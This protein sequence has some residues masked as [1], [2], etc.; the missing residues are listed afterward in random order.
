MD[1]ADEAF[2][3][4]LAARVPAAQ[5]AE[6]HTDDLYLACACA[7]GDARAI[8]IFHRRHLAHL[9]EALAKSGL[10]PEIADEG[11]QTLR[12]QLFVAA[13]GERPLIEGYSGR[14]AVAGWLRVAAMR[15]ASK[16]RRGEARR[17][18]VAMNAAAAAGLPAVD[19]ELSAIRRRYGDASNDAFRDAFGRLTSEERTLLRLRFVDGLNIERIGVV[20]G[21]SR[22]TVGRRMIA[23]RERLLEE[24][25]RALGERIQ[26]TPT[27]V[28]SLLGF[29]RSQLEISFGH[30]VGDERQG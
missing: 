5:I 13:K 17:A 6:A 19:P 29:L 10:E 1:V 7:S 16:V 3:Q 27:E 23:A 14:G 20:L 22:A 30:A 4:Y 11:A 12:A 24:A 26:A 18:R 9:A 2:V 28:R 8:E 15:A 21:L 25:M